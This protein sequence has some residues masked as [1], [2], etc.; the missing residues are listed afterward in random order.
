MRRGC[1]RQIKRERVM[2]GNKRRGSVGREKK[3]HLFW[4]KKSF[5]DI[6]LNCFLFISFFLCSFPRS[7]IL[8]VVPASSSVTPAQVTSRGQWY[9]TWQKQFLINPSYS[10]QAHKMC[11]PQ[12][13]HNKCA[14]INQFGSTIQPDLGKWLGNIKTTLGT[15]GS[16]WMLCAFTM[17]ALYIC[18]LFN[19][20]APY[21][22]IH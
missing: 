21:S 7:W 20:S 18:S 17:C 15:L 5:K 6:T 9:G 4:I 12:Q 16:L 3:N 19:Q 2:G 10:V 14:L 22:F 13:T 11:T 1:G 8:T